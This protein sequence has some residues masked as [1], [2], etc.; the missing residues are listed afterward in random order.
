M[1]FETVLKIRIFNFLYK[2][3]LQQK[4]KGQFNITGKPCNFVDFVDGDNKSQQTQKTKQKA[5][6]T[7]KEFTA[8]V[9]T[10]TKEQ[11]LARN[12]HLACKKV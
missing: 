2:T 5:S 11:S 1:C 10:K 3:L 8:G 7:S 9:Y 12:P 6:Q 4:R